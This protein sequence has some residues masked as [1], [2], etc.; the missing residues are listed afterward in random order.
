LKRATV[1]VACKL[2][3]IMHRVRVTGEFDFG[4]PAAAAK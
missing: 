4:G 1:A 3:A 2:A